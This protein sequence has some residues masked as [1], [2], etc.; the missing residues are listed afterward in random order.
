MQLPHSTHS[1]YSKGFYSDSGRDFAVR[2]MLG[3]CNSG[4]A[5]AGE[6]FAT[7]DSLGNGHER[8]WFEAWH[9]LGRRLV[10]E[11]DASATG[12]HRISAAF[13][14]LR[15]ATYLSEAFDALDGISDDAERMPIFAEHRAAWE[16]FVDN[17]PF[18]AQRLSI[19]YDGTQLP[20]WFFS[21]TDAGDAP[22]PTLVMVNGSDGSVSAQWSSAAHGALQRGYRVVMFDGPGQQSMLFE[23]GMPFRHDWEAVLTPVTD[24]VLGLAGVDA[25]RLAVYGISQAGYW[26]PRAIAFEHRYAAAIADPGVVDVEASWLANI[27][28]PLS[29]RLAEGKD[30]DFDQMMEIGMKASKATKRMW[31]WRARPY[32]QDTYS[33]TMKA[34]AQYTLTPDVAALIRTPMLITSPEHEQFWPG[35]SEQLAKLSGGTSTVVEF[36]AAE[37]AS[38]HCQPMARAL[39]DQ[40]MFD[41]LD[42]QFV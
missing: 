38:W 42:E 24:V 17:G 8:D 29:R 7:I 30:H 15:A 33:G 20:G 37:G 35:Q 22:R 21:P 28:G 1:A 9:G 14:H 40:R 32:G 26:V 13:G 36:T 18:V 25:D 5:D 11:A 6:I 31:D 27:P 16:K 34:V 19:P 3:Y 41:W 2:L 10:A 23:H 12:G 4:A 39:T